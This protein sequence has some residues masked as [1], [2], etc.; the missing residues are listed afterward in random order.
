MATASIPHAIATSPIPLA[1]AVREAARRLSVGKSTV[2][3]LIARGELPVVR[4]GRRT[5]IRTI[6]LEAFAASRVSA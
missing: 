6:D 4:I 5:L 2:W 3:L 1:V